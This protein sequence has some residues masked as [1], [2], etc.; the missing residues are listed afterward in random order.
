MIYCGFLF[1]L[2]IFRK[3]DKKLRGITMKIKLIAPYDIEGAIH[4]SASTFK[5]Q[6]LSLPTLAAYTPRGNEIKLVDEAFSPDNVDEDVDLV[7]ITAMTDLALRAYQIADKYHQRGV[8][9]VMGGIHPKVISHE[10]LTHADSVVIGEG[11]IIWPQVISDAAKGKLQKIYFSKKRANM[12]DRPLP[13]RDLYPQ[14]EYKSYTPL[15]M[16][17]EASRG[18]PYHCDFCSVGKI[19]GHCY[20]TRPVNEVI[21]EI[22][23]LDIHRLIF[24]DDNFA[25]NKKVAKK[26]FNGLIPLKYRWISQGAVS[27]AEDLNLLHLM[28]QSGCEGLLIG[29]ESLNLKTQAQM[30]KLKKLKI[31]FSEAMHR[32]HGEG[33]NI[34]GAFI[35]GFDYDDRKIFQQTLDFINKHK[36]E[37]IQARAIIPYPGT[38]IYQRFLQQGRLLVDNWWLKNINRDKV[39]FRPKGMDP[40]DLEEGL[41]Y[42][43]SQTHKIA[44]IFKRFWGIPPWK[45]PFLDWQLY[46]GINFANRKRFKR[47]RIN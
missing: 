20:R 23:S 18:C 10:A 11:E 44:S 6:Q 45:R 33:I 27:L 22:E 15:T 8:K 36:I 32:F 26:L 4:S 31:D 7:G 13:R 30:I 41:Q 43:I 17:L 19:M 35:F 24:C 3:K 46:G 21:K 25:L 37:I 28:K 2:S 47:F 40:E 42:V 12:I 38:R 14:L 29:F 16:S 34:M 9:V 1:A 39:L 5:I